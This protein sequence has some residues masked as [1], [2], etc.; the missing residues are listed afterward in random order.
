MERL[1]PRQKAYGS[2]RIFIADLTRRDVTALVSDDKAETTLD[3]DRFRIANRIAAIG[4]LDGFVGAS[5][6]GGGE[7][8]SHT[9]AL[10]NFQP[11]T[12]PER[13]IRIHNADLG[14]LCDFI[15]PRL[16]C[17]QLV[18]LTIC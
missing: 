3:D 11:L 2:G 9:L 10:S 16:R 14:K 12:T 1:A 7:S 8:L 15:E 13:G 5:I 17:Q 18:I 6:H 4:N